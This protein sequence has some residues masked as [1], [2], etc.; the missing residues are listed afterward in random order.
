MRPPE[1]SFQ[2]EFYRC[3]WNEVGS[4][5]RISS[6]WSDVGQGRID[7]HIVEPGWGFELLRDEDRLREHCDR[8]NPSVAYH[9]WIQRGQLTDWLI[10]DCRHSYPRTTCR[11]PFS[12]SMFPSSITNVFVSDPGQLRLWRVVFADDWSSVHIL[13]CEN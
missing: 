7:F 1:A 13:D 12:I 2:D 3:F 8:F 9:P 5:V 4:G 11:A 10:L 6:E